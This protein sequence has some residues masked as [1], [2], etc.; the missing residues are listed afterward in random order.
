[1]KRR[2]IFQAA[3][4]LTLSYGLLL[5]AQTSEVSE[6][7]RNFITSTAQTNMLQE[8][9]AGLADKNAESSQVKDLAHRISDDAVG[10][11]NQLKDM[12]SRYS[13]SFPANLDVQHQ[14][15]FNTLSS[16]SGSLFD[17]VFVKTQVRLLDEML[18]S[19]QEQFRN[20]K[21]Q[22]VRDFANSRI[23]TIRQFQQDLRNLRPGAAPGAINVP[24]TKE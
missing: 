21:N 7:D 23:D 19:Y 24:A 11:K 3:L 12:A 14:Q 17:R 9:M 1:M 18:H 16:L 10:V 20:G 8:Q 22:D 13:I 15:T 6:K 2:F 4:L 5:F